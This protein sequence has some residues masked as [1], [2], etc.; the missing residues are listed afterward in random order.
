MIDIF[1]TGEEIDIYFKPLTTRW[2]FYFQIV[3]YTLSN[4]L[5]KQK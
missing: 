4:V 3:T 5:N 1:D 2:E